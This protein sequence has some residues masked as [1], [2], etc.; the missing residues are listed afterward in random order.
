MHNNWSSK[1]TKTWSCGL[2]EEDELKTTPSSSLFDRNFDVSTSSNSGAGRESGSTSMKALSSGRYREDLSRYREESAGLTRPIGSSKA[3]LLLT[4]LF[5]LIIGFDEEWS[6]V[7]CE[8]LRWGVCRSRARLLTAGL[9][10]LE[11]VE[12]EAGEEQE[13]FT[14]L[15]ISLRRREA[16]LTIEWLWEAYDDILLK[17]LKGVGKLHKRVLF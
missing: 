7:L 16:I 10:M 6:F 8:S 1:L 13:K 15:F 5:S 14:D 9:V 3:F 17:G 2:V 4:W 11:H 12:A